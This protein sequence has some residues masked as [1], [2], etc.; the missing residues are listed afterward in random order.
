MIG[1]I[2]EL[3]DIQFFWHIIQLLFQSGFD[4]QPW[5]DISVEDTSTEIEFFNSPPNVLEFNF[6]SL[7][8]AIF[9]WAVGRLVHMK[10]VRAWQ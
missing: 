2:C 8:G 10:H 5:M 4:M 7:I 1:I 3:T 6:D 9:A